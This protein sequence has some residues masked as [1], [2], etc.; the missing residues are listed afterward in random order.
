M[1]LE[2]MAQLRVFRPLG[3]DDSS[4]EWQERFLTNHAQGY[5][6]D[7]EAVPKRRVATAQASWSLLTTATDYLRFIQAVQ[8]ARSLA[9]K[10]HARWFEPVVPVRQGDNA[11]DL[12]GI[13]PPSEHVAW[14]LGWGLEPLQDCFFHW[15]HSP[16]FR[17]YVLGNRVTQDAVV[18]FA[19][20]ARGLRLAHLL[21][22]AAVPG[23]HP[24][25]QWLQ[26]GQL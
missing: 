5:E 9:P 15:G 2:T 1:S 4:L 13:N 19:N 20:S 16:G 12:T 14:G 11:E 18:W 22:P 26:I 7:G 24:S 10:V 21:L 17:A 23:E 3:M 25:V 6:W 8:S